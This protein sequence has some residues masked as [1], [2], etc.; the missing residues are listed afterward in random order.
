MHAWAKRQQEH[1]PLGLTTLSTHDTK[2]SEDVRARLMALA[3]DA[4]SWTRCSEAF[5][6][7]ADERGVDRPTAHLVWQT[8]AGIGQISDDRLE[9]YLTK[10]LRESKEHTSWLDPDVDYERRVLDLAMTAN[11]PGPLRAL[12]DT[13]VD[14]NGEE[15]R[16]FVLGQ[17]LL[18]LTLPGVP[19]VYQGCEVVDLSLVDPDNRRPVDFDVR[20]RRLSRLAAGGAPEDLDDEKLLVTT[21][22]LHLRRELPDAFGDSSRYE[23]LESG[24]RHLVGFVRGREVAVL[25]TRAGQRLD[26][27]GGWGEAT[28]RLPEGLWRDEL[29]GQLHGG[30]DNECAGIFSDLPVALLR[31]VHMT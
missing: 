22:A 11:R 2:R 7:A 14:R 18:Q 16:A 10:A 9:G 19:D 8:L 20:G 25:V 17:K 15:V 4:E 27:G 29:T 31:R 13:A 24:S 6:E 12:V 5:A 26:V 3:G 28:V 30:G 21:T 23:P 1:W